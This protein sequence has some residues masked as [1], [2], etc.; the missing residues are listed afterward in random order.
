MKLKPYPK[1]KASGVDWVGDVPEGWSLKRLAYLFE[2]KKDVNHVDEELLSVYRDH[3][4][5]PKSSRD[6]NFNKPSDDLSPYQLVNRG[7]LVLNK[8]KTWQG[9]IAISEYRGIVSPAYFVATP[10]TPMHLRFIHYLLRCQLYIAEYRKLSAGIRPNQ[11]DLD[12]DH[13]KNIPALLPS[14]DEQSEIAS[15]LDRETAKIDTLIAKQEKLIELLKEKRQAVISHAVT[16]GLD[17]TASMKP[18]GVEWL[19]DVPEHWGLAPL[20]HLVTMSSGGTPSKD[21]EDYWGGSHPWASAKDLKVEVLSDTEDHIS[22]TA[23]QEGAATLVSPGAV[24][25]VVRGMILLHTLPVTVNAVPMA[26]NQDLKAL[27]AGSKL[28][29]SYLAL[30]LRGL[31]REILGRTDQAAHGTKALRMEDWTGMHVPVPPVEDQRKILQHVENQKQ[32]I[33][34]LIIKAQQAVSLQK[35]HRTALISA[36]VTGKIDVR[37]MMNEVKKAA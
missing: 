9:S 5:V 30:M 35:E 10:K 12:Y 25:I 7:D 26:I 4:V 37:S 21:R 3:G 2:R 27:R 34:Q 29:P 36:A 8:M 13:F 1:Y 15:F 33:D 11:W 20:K 6:D 19:G 24:L 18:S 23:I 16:K 31:S 22:N 14:P 32:V 28:L 17:P